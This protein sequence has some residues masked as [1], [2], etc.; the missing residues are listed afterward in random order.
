MRLL[1]EHGYWLAP[2]AHAGHIEVSDVDP[3]DPLG[4]RYARVDWT[5]AA[6]ALDAGTLYG[7]SAGRVLRIACSLG[8][9]VP[10]DLADAVSGLDRTNLALVLAAVSHASGAHEHREYVVERPANGAPPVVTPHTPRL[11]LGP[12]HPWPPQLK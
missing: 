4:P 10:V 3:D 8:A 6:A 5:G 12:L 11:E 1:V 2:L 7:G 9:G